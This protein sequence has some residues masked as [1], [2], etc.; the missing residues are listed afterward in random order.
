MR[1]Y[2]LVFMHPHS[3]ETVMIP[4]AP[5]QPLGRWEKMGKY[6]QSIAKVVLSSYF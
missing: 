6:L 2:C 3:K 4:A 1:S 5:L